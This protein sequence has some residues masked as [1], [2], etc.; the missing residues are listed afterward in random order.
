MHE[1][2][3]MECGSESVRLKPRP[4]K[5]CLTLLDERSARTVLTTS[6]RC[7]LDREG[8]ASGPLFLL[9]CYIYSKDNNQ[10]HPKSV[11]IIPGL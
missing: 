11:T 10:L 4:L 8:V 1:I 6:S 2:P 7:I 5:S 9:H 3:K